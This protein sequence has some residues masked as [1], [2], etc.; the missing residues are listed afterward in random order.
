MTRKEMAAALRAEA[1]ALQVTK[2][3]IG[4]RIT[5]LQAE[6]RELHTAGVTAGTRYSDL[7][8]AAQALEA[9]DG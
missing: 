5:A 1:G 8:G 7:V 6:L 9:L 3:A 2:T 4:A